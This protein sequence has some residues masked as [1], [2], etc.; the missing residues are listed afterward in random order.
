MQIVITGRHLGVTDAM[1]AYAWE[2][3]GKLGRTHERLTK[4]EVTM[5]VAPKGGHVVEMVVDAN[6]ARLVGKAEHAD[7]YAAVD[8]AEDK[9]LRQLV[10]H[11]ERISDHHRGESSMSGLATGST[12]RMCWPGRI[13][14]T[15]RA[16]PSASGAR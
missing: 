12:G 16:K 13:C 14:S 9:L 1:K 10:R 15:T 4:I 6:R 3:A 5:D 7:M 8:L 2:K 11:K